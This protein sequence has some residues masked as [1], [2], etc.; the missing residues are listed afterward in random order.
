MCLRDE[1]RIY[2]EETLYRVCVYGWVGV[3]WGG[4]WNEYP[5]LRDSQNCYFRSGYVWNQENW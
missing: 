1:R 2:C 4:G 5:L 3:G